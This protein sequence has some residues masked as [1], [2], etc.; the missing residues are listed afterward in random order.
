MGKFFM[1]VKT[2]DVFRKNNGDLFPSKGDLPN[3]VNENNERQKI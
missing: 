3:S 1:K 2:A